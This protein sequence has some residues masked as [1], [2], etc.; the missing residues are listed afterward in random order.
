M[1]MLVPT[2]YKQNLV[3]IPYF[4]KKYISMEALKST[5]LI[6]RS[7]TTL[8]NDE[9]KLANNLSLDLVVF[10]LLGLLIHDD[11]CSGLITLVSDLFNVVSR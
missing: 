4:S 7:E 8:L 2:L 9:S 6:D 10:G 11:D 1:T 5:L 3:S